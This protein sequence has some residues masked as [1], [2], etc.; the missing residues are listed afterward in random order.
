MDLDD[1]LQT[2]VFDSKQ[3]SAKSLHCLLHFFETDSNFVISAFQQKLPKTY[4]AYVNPR[5]VLDSGNHSMGHHL[6]RP[7]DNSL[8]IK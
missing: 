2:G 5:T 8:R 4:N 7:G 1:R 3:V 6:Q